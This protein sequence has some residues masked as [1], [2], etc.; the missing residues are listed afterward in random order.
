MGAASGFD[1]FAHKSRTKNVGS[2]TAQCQGATATRQ[3][4][5]TG[6]TGQST[7]RQAM[8]AAHLQVLEALFVVLVEVFHSQ[9]DLRASVP[10]QCV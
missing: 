7:H 3:A 8:C 5:K 4:N 10:F 6:E 9:H 1:P 2:Q